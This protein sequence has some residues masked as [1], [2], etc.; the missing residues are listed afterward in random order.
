VDP[1]DDGS[2]AELAELAEQA[3]ATEELADA[4]RRTISRLLLVRPPVEQLRRATRSANAFADSLDQLPPRLKPW[5]V[6]E[7]AIMPGDLVSFSPISGPGNPI[8][9]PVRMQVVV[10][11]SGRH[12]EGTVTWGPAYEGPPGHCHGGWTAAMFDEVLGFA[13]V[14]GGFTGYLHINYRAP[15]P[16]N[17]ELTLRGWVDRVEG[18]KQ[19]IRGTCHLGET[20]L[21]DAEGLFVSLREGVDVWSH[22]GLA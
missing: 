17:R 16:L 20:L 4:L 1:L 7:A 15:T 3:R 10:D 11:D 22:L 6:S 18:R 2:G 9:P 5:E 14:Q 8:A 13:Q 21:S 19:F 12:I